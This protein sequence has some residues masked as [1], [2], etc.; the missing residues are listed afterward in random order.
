MLV[1]IANF[2]TDRSIRIDELAPA[3][4]RRGFESLW[5]T[6][7]SHIPV[8]RRTPWPG[9]D[10]TLPDHYR[11]SLDPVVAL[12]VAAAC[13]TTLKLGFGIMLLVQRDAIQTAK[14]LSS[15]DH[16]SDGRVICGVGAGWNLEEMG[17]HGVDPA[18]RFKLLR[19]KVLAMQ[20]L[21]NHEVGEFHG[22]LLDVEP[23]WMWP[24]P[25]QTPLPVYLGGNT[26]KTMKRVLSF[27]Q[28]WMPSG[29]L[30]TGL[31]TL[32]RQIVQFRDMC[33]EAGRTDLPVTVFAP[34]STREAIEAVAE[35]GADRV[36][37]Y[38]P[39]TGRDDALA[40]LERLTTMTEDLRT[41]A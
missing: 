38:V 10:G 39:P 9:G 5:L 19:E 14:S 28:G 12:S 23:S 16:L 25:V 20:E 35:V 40:E 17:Q 29:N 21:W 4:E 11:R 7:H 15:L 33:E 26:E 8:S 1:G 41:G 22:E 37:L 13:T 34:E 30:K 31:D 6:E 32:R 24:K 3:V 2:S 36:V 27:G 18:T